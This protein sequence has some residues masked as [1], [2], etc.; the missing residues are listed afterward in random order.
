MSIDPIE[1]WLQE[2]TT[3]NAMELDRGDGYHPDEVQAMRSFLN[4][5]MNAHKAAVAITRPIMLETDPN[6][7]LY[8]LWGFFADAL[9][10]QGQEVGRKSLDLLAAVQ[11]LP[12]ETTP[13]AEIDWPDLKGFGSM[14]FDLH[15]L[16]FHGPPPWE[17]GKEGIMTEEREKI[18]RSL[19]ED[20][21]LA[22]AAIWLRIPNAIDSSLG[23]EVLNLSRSGRA[24]LYIQIHQIRG[25][26]KVAGPQL[27][28]DKA[29]DEVGHYL[30]KAWTGY[31]D[32]P[33]SEHWAAWEAALVKLSGE[34]SSFPFPP[35]S[36]QVAL[37]CLVLISDAKNGH[38]VACQDGDT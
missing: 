17:S 31:I 32:A 5:S 3:W 1:A 12:K 37:D 38:R 24:G 9:V 4:G 7:K 13:T 36:R 16:H 6:S 20:T 27:W 25:W 10:E 29:M 8:R 35:A 2:M 11:A 23:Y 14:W 15:S 22:E 21:G 34:T 26:L 30:E 33:M 19:Y 18:L 28:R